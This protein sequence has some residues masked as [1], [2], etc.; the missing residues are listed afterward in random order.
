[1]NAEALRPA[2]TRP[3]PQASLAVVSGATI[4]LYVATST[5]HITG[6]LQV[7]DLWMLLAGIA[8]LLSPAATLDLLRLV[9]GSY[10]AAA[11]ALTGCMLI[12]TLNSRTFLHSL[13]SVTQMV[14]VLWVLVPVVAAGVA[15]M[16]DPLRFLRLAGL[17]YMAVYMVG[18]V[19]LFGAGNDAILYQSAIGRVWQWPSTH[20][21]QMS[22]MAVSAAG[23]AVGTSHRLRDMT[24]LLLSFIPILLNASRTGFVGFGLLA[25]LGLGASL[26]HVRRLPWVLGGLAV[27]GASGAALVTSAAFQNLWQIRVLSAAGFLEDDI[28]LGS[29]VVSW[30]AIRA[31]TMTMLFGDGWGTSGGDLVVH[32]VVVQVWHEGGIFVLLTM[33]LLLALPVIRPWLRPTANGAVRLTGVMLGSLNLTFW[34]LNALSVE[35]VYWLA[36]AVSLGLAYRAPADSAGIA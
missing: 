12:G 16:R 35:R 9:M 18:L 6:S 23:L 8:V 5:I 28:R 10:G 13:V 31:S 2:V 3:P 26:M 25:V 1:V 36:F 29:I 34:M 4:V 20:V 14:F 17:G 15:R 30:R 27:V 33:L 21:F 22:L 11:L 32:N 19:L 24:L 7:G